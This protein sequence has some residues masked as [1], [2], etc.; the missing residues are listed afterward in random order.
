MS[1]EIWDIAHRKIAAGEDPAAAVDEA[2]LA[3]RD[4]FVEY[5]RGM[6][7]QDLAEKHIA[8]MRDIDLGLDRARVLWS[9][10]STAQRRALAYADKHGG[11]IGRVG[12]EYLDRQWSTPE[13]P[14]QV[15]TVRALCKYDLMAW[16]GGLPDP[17]A[18]AVVTERGRFVLKNGRQSDE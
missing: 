15:A 13:R 2:L 1:R 17:E 8:R 5:L 18:A 6:G 16:D 14:I 12:K 3:D 4:E 9:S 7:R 11:R 10:I